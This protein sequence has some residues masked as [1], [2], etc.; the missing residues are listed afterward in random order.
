MQLDRTHDSH[1][2]GLSLAGGRP[3]DYHAWMATWEREYVF[4]RI[5][6]Q[7]RIDFVSP[8]VRTI[9]GYAPEGLLGQNYQ[10]FFDLDHP[11]QAHLAELSDQFE[12]DLPEDARR[13]VARRRGGEIAFFAIRERE[14]IS[15]SGEFVGKE[16]MALDVTSRVEAVLSLQR[17]EQKFR[18]LVESV[19][20]DYA[21][22]TVDSG[23]KF[24]YVSDSAERLFG[25]PPHDLIG[26]SAQDFCPDSR[27][28]GNHR[29]GRYS[30]R[31]AAFHQ[32][33][34]DVTHRNGARR[35]LE[36]Q[37]RPIFSLDGRLLAVDGIAKDVTAAAAAE[38]EIRELKEDLERR[39]ALRTEQLLRI[40][41]ELR[42]SEARYR[43]VVETQSE[44]IVRWLPDGTRTFVNDAYR[45]FRGGNE[46]EILGSSFFFNVLSDER[47]AYVAM[48]AT[49]TPDN[50]TVS[51]EVHAYRPDGSTACCQW[52]NHAFFDAEGRIVE[53]QSVGR[54]VTELKVAEDL[55]REKELHLAHLSRL[56]TMGEMVAGIA[57]EVSQPLHAAKTFA[58]AA[59]RNLQS[60]RD[61]GALRAVECMTE[62]SQAVARTVEIICR[63]REFT[64]ARGIKYERLSINDVVRES[65]ELVVY[66]V[67]R[68]GVR[69]RLELADGL[70]AIEGDRVQLEQ[71]CVNLVKNA[72]QAMELTPPEQR[73]L[74]VRT[75]SS[76]DQVRLEVEDAGCGLANVD[77]QRLFDAFYSTKDHGMGM[78]LSLCQSIAEAHGM[79]LQF[80]P[81]G[82]GP[83]VTFTVLMP[84]S[85]GVVR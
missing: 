75:Q 43:E 20:G 24:T 34:V 57:H 59:R 48:L 35:K 54:D 67:R 42:A 15:A 76:G 22:F 64:K 53:F 44:F 29:G 26:R 80:A 36:I 45:R 71:L 7:Q 79:K 28:G 13:C 23:G 10:E 56:A 77:E 51:S 11:L 62:I 9:L 70:R 52:T 5:D 6:A 4:F 81:N 39:V 3:F 1:D 37:E 12:A 78:G 16:F 14:I 55:L 2:V 65:I 18:R 63:L 83:G 72:C 50:P 85:R 82:G 41:E 74:T 60:G 31:S 58:E 69:L 27:V 19:K 17:S 47:E 61:D 66:E 25:Y 68:V 49:V 21:L 30:T 46:R 38:Q 33:V 73:V 32:Y 40:N 8:S 84:A